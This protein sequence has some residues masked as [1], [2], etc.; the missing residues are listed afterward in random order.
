M[1]RDIPLAELSLFARLPGC[2][3]SFCSHLSPHL[4]APPWL[5]SSQYETND[6]GYPWVLGRNDVVAGQKITITTRPDA[7]ADAT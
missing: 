2:H 4:M 5:P 6:Q 7:V 3:T 1:T